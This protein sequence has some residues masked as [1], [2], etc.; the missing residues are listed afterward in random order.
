MAS[1]PTINLPS[2][3]FFVQMLLIFIAPSLSAVVTL[4]ILRRDREADT[5]LAEITSQDTY[6]KQAV[7]LASQYREELGRQKATIESLEKHSREQ[8]A[9]CDRKIRL[10]QDQINNLISQLSSPSRRAFDAAQKTP[11]A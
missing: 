9:E 3:F 10:L 6:F 5:E 4:V 1:P 7:E 11:N 2:W 8:E